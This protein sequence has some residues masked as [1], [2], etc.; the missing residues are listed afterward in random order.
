MAALVVNK[1]N[2]STGLVE[3]TK[4]AASGGGDTFTNDGATSLEVDNGGGGAITVTV[5]AVKDCDQGFDHDSV[6]SVG[7]GET[8]RIGP[9][10]KSIFG[11]TPDVSYSGV[12]SVTVAAVSNAT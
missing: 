3:P 10:P 1:I 2:R 5:D 11:S 7:A 8:R 12:T 9:F 6:V 4:A